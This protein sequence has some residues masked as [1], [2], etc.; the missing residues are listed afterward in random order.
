MISFCDL[1]AVR[2]IWIYGATKRRPITQ[3]EIVNE[4]FLPVK[5]LCF[6]GV[7]S[8]GVVL[9]MNTFNIDPTGQADCSQI[10]QDAID[11]YDHVIFK[12]PSGEFKFENPVS[13]HAHQVI[14][15]AGTEATHFIFNLGGAGSAFSVSGSI[16]QNA[17]SV[18][19]P[20]QKNQHFL[21]CPQHNFS[22][23]DWIYQQADD[24][25]LVTSSWAIGTTGQINQV[26][27]VSNDTIFLKTPLRRAYSG[28]VWVKPYRDWETCRT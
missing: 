13:L 14:E 21:L 1:R 12:F 3:A 9:D 16:A 7:T 15:G 25:T 18:E 4:T 5:R 28:A 27:H 11:Q 26:L 24:T 22:A 6:L 8:T 17:V 19:G 20:L 2:S 10:L 23:G